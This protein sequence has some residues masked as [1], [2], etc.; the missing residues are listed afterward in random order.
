MAR[1]KR[2]FKARRRRK[3]IMAAA[4]GYRGAR[5]RTLRGALQVLRRGLVY[6]YRDRRVK[7]RTSRRLWIVK[8]NAACRALGIKYSQF[9]YGLKKDG[10]ELDRS[11]L[12]E[13]AITDRDAFS[14]LVKRAKGAAGL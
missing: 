12:A 5:H 1:V 8:I 11:V 7:K 9:V 10:I 3:K 14:D 4:H 13:L 2:G 6:A